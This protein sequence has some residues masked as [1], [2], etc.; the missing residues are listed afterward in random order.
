MSKHSLPNLSVRVAMAI[1]SVFA[2]LAG[3]Q[4]HAQAYPNHAI[5]ILAGFPAGGPTDIAM[6]AMA[7]SASKTL[8]HPV[9]VENVPGAGGAVSIVRLKNASA[10]G[11]TL[12]MLTLGVFRSPVMEDVGYDPIKDLTY[13]IRLTNLQF[14]I[15]VRSESPWK[16][17]Q[18]FIVGARANPDKIS[19]GVAAGL[20][21]S[22]HLLM[23]EVSA[24][25]GLRLTVV[26]YK[27]SADVAQALMGGHIALSSDS[28]GGFGTLVESGKARLLAVASERRSPRWK[29][30]PTLQ[31]LGYN[32]AVDSPWGIGGPKG[33]D[34]ATVR[35][36]HDA[37]RK[38][39]EDAA[40][41]KVLD[42][43]GQGLR[44][45]NPEEYTRYAVQAAQEERAMLT[46]Y[47]FAKKQ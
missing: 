42:Q 6:R 47:G 18:D 23:E 35:I 5:R 26:P 13:I 2:F 31:E 44:Y 21:N 14:G 10:D 12:G 27:G 3:G 9:I 17:W 43:F 28:S 22:A 25:D 1:L 24:R 37:F 19:Y 34:P 11:Y 15:V 41:L 29:D 36:V 33:M 8:G 7:Q 39:L 46:K 16:M 20:G 40:V 32:V 45:M 4:A 38:A 30:I